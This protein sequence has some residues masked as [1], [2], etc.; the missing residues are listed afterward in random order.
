MDLSIYKDITN[1]PP[2][3]RIPKML[4][5]DA[6]EL[7]TFMK[8]YFSQRELMGH[9][10]LKSNSKLYTLYNKYNIVAKPLIFGDTITFSVDED[11]EET[12]EID[13]PPVNNELEELYKAIEGLMGKTGDMK[14]VFTIK[15]K[16]NYEKKNIEERVLGILESMCESHRYSISLELVELD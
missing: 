14:N 5:E 2:L 9:Y 4:E 12:R 10:E 1:L 8:S 6:I 3:H 7:L 13:N 11:V 15:F 16:G